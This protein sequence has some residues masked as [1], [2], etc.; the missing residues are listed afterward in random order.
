GELGCERHLTRSAG[1]SLA[2]AN[3]P[4]SDR[5]PVAPVFEVRPPDRMDPGL[6]LDDVPVLERPGIHYLA[7]HF[8]GRMLRGRAFDAKYKSG[9]WIFDGPDPALNALIER[10]A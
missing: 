9:T 4:H 2:G 10:Y 3:A 6:C 8:G 1:S 5:A 7:T